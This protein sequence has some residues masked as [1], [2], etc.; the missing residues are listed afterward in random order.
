[1][2]SY[3]TNLNL[4][5]STVGGDTNAWGGHLNG[6]A[7]TIDGIFADAGNGTSVGL[8]VGSGKT[9]TVAGTANFTGTTTFSSSGFT[10]NNYS[11]VD[12]SS[13]F[14]IGAIGDDDE[15]L[16]LKGFGGTT[17][18]VLGE[19]NITVT[20]SVGIGE[21]SPL[22]NLHIK[23]ADAGAFTPTTDITQLIIEDSGDSGIQIISGSDAVAKICFGHPS[24]PDEGMIQYTHDADDE[25]T[26]VAGSAFSFKK[27]ATTQATLN[28]AGDLNILTADKGV[29]LKS[30]NGTQYRVTV[31][32]A[33]ALV[34][35]AI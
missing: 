17:S 28:S 6:N 35:T 12:Y 16:T 23:S 32:N 15:N 27:G 22:S 10:L 34:V 18:M 26:F 5:K 20:G 4:T 9:L 31:S 21:S 13:G 2:P 25:M 24:D 33:G 3:T 11:F 1:M 8:N 14:R 30:A 19:N 29:V 7:D